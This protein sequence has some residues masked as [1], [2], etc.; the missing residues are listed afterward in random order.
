MSLIKSVASQTSGSTPRDLRAL[1]VD[2]RAN[3]VCRLLKSSKENK[4]HSNL[5]IENGD[6]GEDDSSSQLDGT[7]ADGLFDYYIPWFLFI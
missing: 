7:I 5:T 4:N 6:H 3:A 2:A 1:A